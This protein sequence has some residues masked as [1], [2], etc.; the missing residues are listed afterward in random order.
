M[1]VIRSFHTIRYLKPG[2]VGNRLLRGRRRLRPLSGKPLIPVPPRRPWQV[3]AALPPSLLIDGLATF[4]NESGPLHEWQ[5]PHKSRL[6]L[7]NLHYFDDLVAEGCSQREAVHRGMI[8]RWLADN[9]PFDGIGWEPYPLSLR[10]VNWIKWLLLGNQP[11]TGMLAI[12]AAQAHALSQQIEYH[13]RGNHLL[14][15]A[16]ALIFAGTFFEGKA[17]AKWLKLGLKLLEEQLD[18]QLL[19]DGGHFERSPMYHNI[20]LLDLLDLIQL[21]QL[22]RTGDVARRLPGLRAA[23]G[24]MAG[25]AEGMLHPD[26]QIS[27]FNDAAFGITPEPRAILDYSRELGVVPSFVD[28][29]IRHFDESGYVSVHGHEQ[30]A[31]L[32]VAPIGPDYIPGHAHA[33]TLSF[34]WSLFGSRVLVNSGTSEYG[35]SE[36]RQRQRGTAAHNT[37]AVRGENSSEIWAGFRVARRARPFDLK[38]GVA[39]KCSIIRASH[40]GYHRL[41]PKVT[42]T[43]EWRVLPGALE[44]SD[45]L[46]GRYRQAVAYFHFHPAVRLVASGNHFSCSLPGGRHCEV[47]VAGGK[48]VIEESSWHPEFGVSQPNQRLA[49]SFEG[50]E[51]KTA[52]RY[53]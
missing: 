21:G 2:Q 7:Y 26:G 28:S 30:V 31:L 3:R 45:I 19:K 41:F 52:F 29:T 32:D 13:L 12:L 9:P 37:V 34:E 40:S 25:W 20:V 16:K 48:A 46:A 23:A 53:Q 24:G 33:D 42:H 4:L 36:E 35:L 27:F 18:E 39:G 47:R 38:L 1:S 43:R 15:N 14:A 11:V 49:I 51:L 17:A 22:Y 10:T 50:P 44:V 6:W 5:N 8:E